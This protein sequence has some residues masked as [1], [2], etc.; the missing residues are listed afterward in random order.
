MKKEIFVL[1]AILDQL[2]P[3]QRKAVEHSTGPLLIMAGAGVVAYI[4]GEG[5]ADAAERGKETDD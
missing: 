3:M 1:D 5:L 2:N 4:L